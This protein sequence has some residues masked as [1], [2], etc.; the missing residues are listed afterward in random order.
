[1]LDFYCFIL[2]CCCCCCCWGEEN[3][4][5]V[6]SFRLQ[7]RRLQL[8]TVGNGDLLG[9]LAGLAAIRLNL[10]D[11]VHALNDGAKDN[12]TIVEPGSF[13]GCNEELGAVGVGAGIGHRHNTGAG[14]LQGEVLILKLVAVDGLAA[15]TVVVG[16]ISSLAHEVGDHTVEGGS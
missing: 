14:M 7:S 15:G 11:N 12:M 2:Y 8:A 3:W 13:D 4:S 5:L 6:R 16:E 1:M 10:L 9:C